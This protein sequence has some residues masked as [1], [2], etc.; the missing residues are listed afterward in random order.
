MA[1]NNG[2]DEFDNFELPQDDE[3]L[4]M[5]LLDDTQVDDCDCEKLY[6]VMRSLEAEI[7]QQTIDDDQ[8]SSSEDNNN[9][10]SVLSDHDH[11]HAHF[12]GHDKLRPDHGLD[13][14][15]MDMVPSSPSDVMASSWYMD[16]CGDEMDAVTQ[17]GSGKDLYYFQHLNGISFEDHEC[18]SSGNLWQET[19]ASLVHLY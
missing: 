3:A 12:E 10:T 8:K 16:P 9:W 7:D 2:H 1:C 19:N 5:S 4:L 6:S 18:Y 14:D 17:F 11:D 13:F 15:W